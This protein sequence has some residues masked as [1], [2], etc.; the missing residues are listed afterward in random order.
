[1]SRAS[2][3]FPVGIVFAVTLMLSSPAMRAQTGSSIGAVDGARAT[4][5]IAQ[6]PA[7]SGAAEPTSPPDSETEVQLA[8]PG[9][10]GQAGP[11]LTLTLADALDRA[12]KNDAEYLAAV[13]D[14]RTAHEGRIQARASLLPSVSTTTQELLTSGASVL[15]TGK[16]VT[17][18]GVHV[19]RAWGVFHEELSPNLFTM[20]GYKRASAEES[21]AKA[22]EEIARRGV[23]VTV[24]EN[25]YAL[26]SAGRKYATAQESANQARQFLQITLDREQ[27]GEA[28]HS[29]VIKA[30][31]QLD[32]RQQAFEEA[33]LAMDNARLNLAVLLF[34]TL[35]E[36]FEVVDDLDQ[37]PGLPPF[38]DARAMAA[39]SNP[40]MEA[41]LN[42]KRE[43]DLD[44]SAARQSFLP[45][46]SI[47]TDY[48]IEANAFALRSTAA[49]ASADERKLLQNN[50]GQFTSA[51]LQLPIWD[52]G[53]LRSKLHQA[54][55]HREQARVELSLAQR[56]MVSGLYASYNEAAVA[57]SAASRLRHAAE[58]ASESLR[59]T[60]LRYKDGESTVLEVV[61]AQNSLTDARN[62]SDDAAVRYRVALAN[63]Q[64]VTGS[65]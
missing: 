3:Q 8:G 2:S 34:P 12:R 37:A 35:N 50:L 30:E 43:A 38:E 9:N 62:A 59:L 40:A 25:Y 7:Q 42:L 28:A 23:A 31:L 10:A 27:A 32:Q 64:T 24:T 54:E 60:L 6:T 22:K 44:V 33:R 49:G 51:N 4:A 17:N 48:G 15:P 29:D 16:F 65:F 41:A 1:M 47:D 19:Y 57:H 14:A 53:I 39:R 61:D 56:K 13:T 36:N 63:L 58:L 45:T 52:W 46:I 55:F 18:D 21:L 11:P 20:N 5:H 26:A